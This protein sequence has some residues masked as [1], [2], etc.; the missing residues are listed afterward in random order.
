MS[1]SDVARNHFAIRRSHLRCMK[2]WIT[3]LAF[4]IAMPNAVISVTQTIP[5]NGPTTLMTSRP[6]SV[7]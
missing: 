4:T 6:S 1:T 3:R 5:K 7:K 2:F